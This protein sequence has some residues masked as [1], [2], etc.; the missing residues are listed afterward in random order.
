M[1]TETTISVIRLRKREEE[2]LLQGHLWIFSNEI[3]KPRLP[4]EPGGLVEVRTHADRFLGIGYYNPRS[5]IAVRLLS[6]EPAVPDDA[7]FEARIRKAWSLRQTFF[8]KESAYRVVFGESDGLPGLIVDRYGEYVVVQALTAG[9]ERLLATAVRA[10]ESVFRPRGILL[11]NDS[12]FRALE[13]L[14]QETRLW[15]GEIPRPAVFQRNGLYWAADLYEGHKTGFYFDQAENY[16]LLREGTEGHRVLDA[17][18]YAGGWAVHAARFGAETVLGLDGSEPALALARENA[19]RNGLSD[20]CTFKK[21]EVFEELARLNRAGERFDTVILDPPA[22]VKS[23][24]KIREGIKGYTELNRLALRLVSPG[25]RLITSSCSHHVT[26]EDFRAVLA[27]AG[28][29][30]GRGLRILEWR[31][32]ARDHPMLPAMPETAYLK[33]VVASVSLY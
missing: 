29:L 21:A 12:T 23:R 22:F 11:R 24:Q 4:V 16:L 8:P 18:C 33:C 28:H 2:R 1:M 9:I 13:G 17:F 5:L 7:F 15:S 10:V 26:S 20:R 3:Q 31:G 27:R 14:P 6:R 25:G 30:S 32:Q 19:K